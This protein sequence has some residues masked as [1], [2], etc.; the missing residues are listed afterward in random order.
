MTAG[1]HYRRYV[2]SGEGSRT[3]VTLISFLEEKYVREG[4]WI[5]WLKQTVLFACGCSLAM[6]FFLSVITDHYKFPA[7]QE[8]HCPTKF[9]RSEP[10]KTEAHIE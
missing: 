5:V 3:P 10:Q 7:T 1:A 9:L 2:W 8:N 6:L 4:Y